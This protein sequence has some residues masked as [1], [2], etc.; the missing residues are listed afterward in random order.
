M[1]NWN[2]NST[3]TLRSVLVCKPTHY[4]LV[5]VSDTA[6][7]AQDRGET[8]NHEVAQA[9]H[10]EMVAM[11]K[12]EGIDCVYIKPDPTRHWAVYA[13]MTKDGALIGRFRY[14]ERKGEEVQAEEALREYGVPIIGHITKG[15]FEGGDCW[16]IDEHT[17]AVGCGN[18]STNSGI[19]EA[20]EILAKHDIEVIS[21]WASSRG[22]ATGSST[23]RLG[24]PRGRPFSTSCRSG[25]TAS[26]PFLR[27]KR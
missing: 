21:S 23:S 6:R 4:E 11:L 5:P 15:A 16:Y 24:W 19:D 1:P 26:C 7:D 25:R 22:A 17:L 10:D 2:C 14:L 8:V 13:R 20:A 3:G 9:E 12:D 27:T 18:R